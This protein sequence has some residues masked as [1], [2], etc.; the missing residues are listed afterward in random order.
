MI[1]LYPD[2]IQ[3]FYSYQV[4]NQFYNSL[5]G[6]AFALA[7]YI[8]RLLGGKCM[9]AYQRLVIILLITV[10]GLFLFQNCANPEM[11]FQSANGVNSVLETPFQTEAEP[12]STNSD[13]SQDD[14]D[15]STNHPPAP[16]QVEDPV[17][18][19]PQQPEPPVTT[20][21]KVTENLGLERNESHQLD[22][23]WVIDNSRS[24]E[25][26]AEHV[27]N[28]YHSFLN[29][30]NLSLDIRST[31]ISQKGNSGTSVSIPEGL[32]PEKHMQI[33]IKVNSYDS[34]C[35]THKSIFNGVS[36]S[37][38]DTSFCNRS[39][40]KNLDEFFRPTSNKVFVF[41]TDD[42]EAYVSADEFLNDFTARYGHKPTVYSFIG[43]GWKTSNCQDGTGRQYSALS[44]MTQGQKFNICET[45]WTSHFSQLVDQV[46]VLTLNTFALK[47]SNIE[48][49]LSVRLNGELL[50]DSKY[51]IESG[52]LKIDQTTLEQAPVDARVEVEYV[53]D[54]K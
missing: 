29:S 4:S 35:I 6:M 17:L 36:D 46:R 20:K 1:R 23:V 37:Q 9:R 38:V 10:P 14:T 11:Q 34:I 51:T 7:K 13:N 52:L 22:I 12:Q 48:Q 2:Q 15:I 41:V 19:P 54:Q 8:V 32:D 45:D 47:Y 39:E 26:E 27:R 30:L 49:V 5:T 16:P 31:L 44:D 33:D 50:E 25:A 3:K 28:N 21:I 18:P 40:G 42:N 53:I 24:M 43:L